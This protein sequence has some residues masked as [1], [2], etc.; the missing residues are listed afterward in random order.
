MRSEVNAYFGA[1]EA[2]I[3]PVDYQRELIIV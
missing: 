3:T 2:V 1:R